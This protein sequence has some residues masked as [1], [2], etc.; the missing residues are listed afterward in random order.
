M[1]VVML[2]FLKI[3]KKRLFMKILL[4]VE[5]PTVFVI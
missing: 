5:K 2:I 1:R 4:T 3:Y